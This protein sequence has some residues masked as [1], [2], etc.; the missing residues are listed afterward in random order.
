V[1]RNQPVHFEGFFWLAFLSNVPLSQGVMMSSIDMIA[2]LIGAGL[3]FHERITRKQTLAFL[4]V[5]G[6]VALVGWGQI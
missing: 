4:C 5:A 2:V 1:V 3:L 6:G